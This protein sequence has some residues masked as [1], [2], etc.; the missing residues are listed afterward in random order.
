[1]AFFNQKEEVIDI[2]LTQFGKNALARGVFK[3]V[4]YRFFDD[5]ILYNSENAG[6]TEHQNDTEKRILEETPRLKTQHMCH[7]VETQYFIDDEL[8][9]DREKL[10]FEPLRKNVDFDI[11][12]KILQYPLGEQDLGEEDNPRFNIRSYDAEFKNH[13][14]QVEMLDFD[15]VIRKVPQLTIEPVYRIVMDYAQR[16]ENERITDEEHFDF[17]SDSVKFNSGLSIEKT[18]QNIILDIEEV[19]T[20]YGLDNFEIEVFEVEELPY[21]DSSGNPQ[22]KENLKKIDSLESLREKFVIKTD[23]DVDIEEKKFSKQTNFRREEE[24]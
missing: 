18:K 10:R 16:A 8:I 15:G 24:Y 1:M 22:T 21:E 14:E 12:D 19:A 2:K 23:E 13:E 6:F 3:P 20:F 5:G 4:Y 17:M 11:E 9:K 7:G